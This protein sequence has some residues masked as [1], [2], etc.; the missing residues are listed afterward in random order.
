MVAVEDSF[1]R[2]PKT[3]SL[4]E[5]VA[6]SGHTNGEEMTSTDA[7]SEPEACYLFW[8][9][10]LTLRDRTRLSPLLPSSAQ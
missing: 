9:V 1:R 2:N 5:I 7:F 8:H 4:R 3:L 10:L 6:K